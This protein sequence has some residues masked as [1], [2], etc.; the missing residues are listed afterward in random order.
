M[1]TVHEVHFDTDSD[2][3]CVHTTMQACSEVPCARL[4][5]MPKAAG[6]E[7]IMHWT[8]VT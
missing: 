1:Q 4:R 8:A 7:R 6:C 5:H 2:E 3:V